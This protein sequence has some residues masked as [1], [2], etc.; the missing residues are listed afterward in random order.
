[1]KILM[2]CKYPPIQGG[3]SAEC[4]WTA[5]VLAEMGHEIR[6]LTN[7]QEVEEGYR[8]SMSP[9]DEKLLTGFK[10]PNSVEVFSTTMDKRHVFIPQTNPSVSKLLSLG[11]ELVD[12]GRPDLIWS[13]YLEPYGVVAYLLSKITGVP[14]IF[15]HA[16]SDIGRLMLTTQLQTI[17]HEVLRNAMMILTRSSHHDRFLKLG[18]PQGK[19]VDSVSVKLRPEL[20]FPT[21]FSIHDHLV[22]GVYGKVG[23]SKGTG[24]LIGAMSLLKKE[25]FRVTL[26]AHWGGRDLPRYLRQIQEMDV[27][28]TMEVKGFIPHWQIPDFIR[29]CNAVLFLENRFNITFHHPS[30]PLEII[31]CGR[32]VI[33]TSEV[34]NK[35]FYQ[36][37]LIDGVNSF[38][39]KE[40]ITVESVAS[41]IK[42][43][44][45]NLRAKGGTDISCSLKVSETRLRILMHK[46]VES[47]NIHLSRLDI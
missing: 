27:E 42:R 43:A 38:V 3:V 34:A 13:H 32:P 7:A 14:Y 41:E 17:H 21:K 19:L 2:I 23:E 12:A 35:Q 40:D 29:S 11:L 5:Q 24:D 30:T 22:L 39:I 33:T 15:R 31:S 36:D 10:D 4:Y 37:L 1:M 47:F 44:S 45:K 8:I 18:V 20:F 28:D 46:L 6:V 9:E 16:G 26:Q 25:G